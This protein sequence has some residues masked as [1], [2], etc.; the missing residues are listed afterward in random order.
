VL[1]IEDNLANLRL[2]Q[3]VFSARHEIEIIPALQ[4]RLG[5]DL[6]RQHHPALILLDLH[7]PDLPG[8]E[9]LQQLCDD[10]TTASIPVVILS[11]DATERQR[12][13]LLAAGASA[14]LTKP[15]D[16]RQLLRIVDE[17]LSEPTFS[18]KGLE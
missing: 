8:D 16:I 18:N 14:Y 10:P 5:I 4:G 1:Y 13:R 11:A 9:V 3:R 2:V 17:L 12:Q 15:L 6:A 7:L